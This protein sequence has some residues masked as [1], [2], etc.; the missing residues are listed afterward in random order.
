[1]ATLE[2]LKQSRVTL[3]LATQDP[4]LLELCSRIVVLSGGVVQAAG[5]A[6]DV[7][8]RILA[9]RRQAAGRQ[10]VYQ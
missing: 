1:M 10:A 8:V 6:A 3:V 5:P 9:E 7:K 4:R 2:E